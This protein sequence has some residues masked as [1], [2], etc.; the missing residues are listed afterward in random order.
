MKFKMRPHPITEFPLIVTQEEGDLFD[1]KFVEETLAW[2]RERGLDVRVVRGW[3]GDPFGFA[4]SSEVDAD[5]FM[6][7]R[8]QF[9][10]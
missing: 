9:T 6:L 5:F 10:E 7:G 2:A 3:R 1:E 4:F 8:N